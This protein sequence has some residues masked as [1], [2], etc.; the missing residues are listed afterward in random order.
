MAVCHAPPYY[1]D[2]LMH[3]LWTERF[4][5]PQM[6]STSRAAGRIFPRSSLLRL[7]TKPRLLKQNL[8]PHPLGSVLDPLADYP[9]KS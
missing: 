2:N 7:R 6:I 5:K 8:V 3:N 9:N 4:Y 1:T